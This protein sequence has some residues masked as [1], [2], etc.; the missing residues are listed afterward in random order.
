MPNSVESPTG[1]P[2]RTLTPTRVRV[3]KFPRLSA[4]ALLVAMGIG[5]VAHPI[6]GEFG[7]FLWLAAAAVGV[8]ACCD[9]ATWAEQRIYRGLV[10]WTWII[11][12]TLTLLTPVA[13]I[14]VWP[15]LL[16]AGGVA[17][18]FDD[19]L[20]LAG[21]LFGGMWFISASLGTIVIVSLDILISALILDF[22]SRIQTAALGLMA[23]ALGATWSVFLLGSMAEDRVRE[24]ATTGMLPPKMTIE[25]GDE[26][27]EGQRLIEVLASAENGRV[28]TVGFVLMAALLGLPAIVSACGKLADAVMER[29]NPLREAME[30]IGQGE[31][32]LRVEVGGSKDLRQISQGF[33]R[34]AESLTTTL[35]DLDVRNR[36]LMETNEAT[37][38]FVPF[39]F[40]K[41]LDRKTIRTIRRGDQAQLNMSVMFCDI[42]SFTTIAER[43]RR[44]GQ[45]R[46][47]QSLPVAHGGRGSSR[48]RA[49][50]TT[51]LATVSWPCFTRAPTRRSERDSAC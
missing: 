22:R 17:G 9:I 1:G 6:G 14:V 42:R 36:E 7:R 40:L 12:V 4:M 33:N 32:D 3:V 28:L 43:I 13:F 26:I 34:M 10:G 21:T 2:V 15:F 20:L 5:V 27:L 24:L 38:R 25:V 19:G 47:H 35:N 48:A 31:L 44:S 39:Q 30:R 16:M 50:S 11:R 49:S 8:L 46:L 18:I 37:S 45:L 29:L 51:S 23:V 41:L